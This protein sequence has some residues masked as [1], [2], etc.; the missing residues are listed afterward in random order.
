MLKVDEAVPHVHELLRTSAKG[1]AVVVWE[2][3]RI[4]TLPPS[5]AELPEGARAPD[6]DWIVAKFIVGDD[7]PDEEIRDRLNVGLA[8]GGEWHH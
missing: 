4:T 7:I 3:G 2:D 1:S 6:E 5:E 8:A